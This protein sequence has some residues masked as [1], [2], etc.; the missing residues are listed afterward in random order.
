M[1]LPWRLLQTQSQTLRQ[2]LP[3]TR[4]QR[5]VPS[6]VPSQV[7]SHL[8]I[9]QQNLQQSRPLSLPL[10]HQLDLLRRLRRFLRPLL[11]HCR[12]VHLPIGPRAGLQQSPPRGLPHRQRRSRR[13]C[14]RRSPPRTRQRR[15]QRTPRRNQVENQRPVLHLSLRNRPPFRPRPSRRPSTPRPRK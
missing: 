11:V 13:L 3:F 6:P 5:Q 10:F 4:L 2:N 12:L 8:R 15:R 7:Q 9:R 1:R 14:R